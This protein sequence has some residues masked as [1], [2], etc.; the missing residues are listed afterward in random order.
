M[1]ILVIPKILKIYILY[2]KIYIIN[3]NYSITKIKGVAGVSTL[4]YLVIN[5]LIGEITIVWDNQTN[6]LKEILLPDNNTKK[7]NLGNISY[8]GVIFEN[9][10]N[11][12]IQG[13]M[14]RIKDAV[15]GIDIK[16]D[17][18]KLDLSELTDFQ[19]A[20]LEKQFEIPHGKVTSYKQLA[21]MIGKPRSARPIAN[22][23]ASNPFPI[24]IPC[25]R[26]VL[27]N[28][29]VG[30]YAGK[31]NNYYKKFL[32]SN[33]GVKINGDNVDESCRYIYED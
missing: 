12:Y 30:G 1:L 27:A 23:L 21:R 17:F 2:L 11:K 9:H 14:P 28:W 15:K 13:L 3:L 4:K 32:L 7:S 18:N 10:P 20:V 33:E 26:T 6:I 31:E 16:F 22:V 25:H 19:R 29:D 24:I 8:N 5:T